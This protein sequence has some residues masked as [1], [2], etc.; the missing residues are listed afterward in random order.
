MLNGVKER[1]GAPQTPPTPPGSYNNSLPSSSG[2]QD[3]QRVRQRAESEP[4]VR[5]QPVQCLNLIHLLLLS[6]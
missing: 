5:F 2:S 1:D 3:H 6:P 4:Q